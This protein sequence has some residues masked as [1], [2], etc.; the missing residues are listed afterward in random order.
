M[1]SITLPSEHP[2]LRSQ[3]IRPTFVE[4]DARFGHAAPTVTTGDIVHVG[5]ERAPAIFVGITPAGCAWVTT[6]A[7]KVEPQRQALERLWARAVRT[8]FPAIRVEA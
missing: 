8:M 5:P 2:I 7:L 6:D 1:Y 4:A 3:G